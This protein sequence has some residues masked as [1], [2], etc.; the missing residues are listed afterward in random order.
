MECMGAEWTPRWFTRDQREPHTGEPY[1]RYLGGYWETRKTQSKPENERESWEEV[2]EIY[3]IE[4]EPTV[5]EATAI[6]A[7]SS[8][9]ATLD[10]QSDSQPSDD[11]GQ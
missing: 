11:A 8:C 2:F 1:W 9:L 7:T 4:S 10:S 3:Q 5:T 6:S